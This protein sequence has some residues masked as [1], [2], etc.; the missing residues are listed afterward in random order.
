M[1]LLHLTGVSDNI[2]RLM[3]LKDWVKVACGKQ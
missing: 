3:I 1:N 2:A